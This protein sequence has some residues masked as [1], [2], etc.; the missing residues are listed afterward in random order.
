MADEDTGDVAR[1]TVD[2]L[3]ADLDRRENLLLSLTLFLEDFQSIGMFLSVMNLLQPT[4]FPIFIFVRK[5]IKF[6]QIAA[7]DEILFGVK[8][9]ELGL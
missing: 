5:I 9:I 3:V 7:L 1:V 8:V 4:K 2:V 6:D